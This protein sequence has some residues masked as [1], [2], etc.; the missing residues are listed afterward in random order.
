LDEVEIDLNEEV[1]E[2]KVDESTC[3]SCG[4]DKFFEM[5]ICFE[6]SDKIEVTERKYTIKRDKRQKYSCK[7]CNKITTAD[8]GVKLTPAGE[9]SIQ[10][11]TQ[12]SCDK[13]E[14]HLSLERQR[15][16]EIFGLIMSL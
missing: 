3:S 12:I 14:D 7:C 13:F 1:V 4:G 8:G 10:L 5:K 2:H 9:Y 6:E 16:Q 11:S 15:K